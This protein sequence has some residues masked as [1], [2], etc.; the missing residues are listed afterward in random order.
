M[1]YL[2]DICASRIVLFQAEQVK[3]GNRCDVIQ[4]LSYSD[5]QKLIIQ[6]PFMEQQKL[7]FTEF[8][9]SHCI[10]IPMNEWIVNQIKI[11]ENV[12]QNYV[13]FPSELQHLKKK[14]RPIWKGEKSYIQT[15]PCFKVVVISDNYYDFSNMDTAY[16]FYSFRLEFPHVYI[17]KHRNGETYSIYATCSHV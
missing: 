11:I 2:T 3:I 16:G 12:V 5:G 10:H 8:G 17:G 15:S 6:T 14:F 9:N 13:I 7:D 4:K 1:N